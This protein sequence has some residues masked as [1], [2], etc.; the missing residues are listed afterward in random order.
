[1]IFIFG[2]VF[3]F[4]GIVMLVMLLRKMRQPKAVATILEVTLEYYEKDKYQ[5]KMHPHALVTY[6]YNSID[7]TGKIL[8]G[9]RKAGIGEQVRVSFNADI[10][11]KPTMYAPKQ[12]TFF[13]LLIMVIGLS[14]IA[15]SVFAMDY[16]DL[17]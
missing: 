15:A 10:P 14:L 5:M 6:N 3:C 1:M 8:F 13:A 7:Y 16:F 11:D 17:W 2:L 9:K 4:G 12:E